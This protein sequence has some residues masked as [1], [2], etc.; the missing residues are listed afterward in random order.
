MASTP[1]TF[2]LIGGPTVL[3]EICG[4]RLLTDPTFDPPQ[5]YGGAVPFEKRIGPAVDAGRLGRIDAVLLSH[6]QHIDNLDHAGRALLDRAGR[7]LTT[8]EGARRIGGDG[9]RPWQ[10][11]ELI[12]TD[13][14]RVQITATTARHG[15]RGFERISGD[16]IGFVVS[17]GDG[18]RRAL[19]I[20][21][22]TVWYD[23]VAE[24]ARHFDVAAAIL[25]AG[26]A[27]PRGAFRMTMDVNDVIEAA[28][29]FGNARIIPVHSDGWSHYIQ[30]TQDMVQAFTTLQ[31]ASRL[32]VLDPGVPFSLTL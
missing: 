22:D 12:A 31:L 19:Y 21:G 16:V 30:T 4:L 11:T 10:Y 5:T 20:S 7:V 8:A 2:T 24:V 29:A 1:A 17:R 25:F 15:P 26:S 23:G 9:M 18:T 28:G 3:I 13:G 32:Q 6:D 27:Q 14:S